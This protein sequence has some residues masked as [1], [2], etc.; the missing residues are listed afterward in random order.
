MTTGDESKKK[1]DVV[2]CF[3]HRSLPLPF[4]IAIPLLKTIISHSPDPRLKRRH[5][6]RLSF[7]NERPK[8]PYDFMYIILLLFV[9]REAFVNTPIAPKSFVLFISVQP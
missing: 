8:T 5:Y 9:M 7:S 1:D 6:T 2:I 4:Y 3:N